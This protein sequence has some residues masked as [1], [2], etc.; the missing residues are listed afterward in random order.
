MGIL[1]LLSILHICLGI[2]LLLFIL[3]P[4]GILLLAILFLLGILLLG[5]L[6]SSWATS[7]A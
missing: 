7:Y 6:P 2:L 3:L 5:I 4:L 1:L